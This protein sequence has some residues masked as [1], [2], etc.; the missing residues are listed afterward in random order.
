MKF[1]GMAYAVMGVMAVVAAVVRVLYESFDNVPVFQYVHFVTWLLCRASAVVLVMGSVI[2][3]IAFFRKNL[4]KDEGYFM[5]TLPVAGWQ[6]FA[7]KLITGTVWIFLSAAVAVLGYMIGRLN[8]HIP[9][10]SMLQE[11]GLMEQRFIWLF[12]LLLFVSIPAMLCQFYASLAIGYTWRGLDNAVNRDILSVAAL[13]VTYVV[14]QVLSVIILLVCILCFSGGLKADMMGNFVTLLEG[15][16]QSGS[17]EQLTSYV[18]AI[19]G[20]TFGEILFMGVVFGVIT[21]RRI[22]RHLNME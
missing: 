13:V 11:S 19:L 5:H 20:A 22:H 1:F 18:T 4:F 8:F 17:A 15:I 2:Y 21:V 14:Q 16:D 10:L 7:G 6:L 3:V 9:F 12:V